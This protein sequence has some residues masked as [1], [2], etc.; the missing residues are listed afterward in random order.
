[1]L[2]SLFNEGKHALQ[3]KKITIGAECPIVGTDRV[4]KGLEQELVTLTQ[5]A[6]CLP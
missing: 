3:K 1:M 5:Q 6:G 2:P 4:S